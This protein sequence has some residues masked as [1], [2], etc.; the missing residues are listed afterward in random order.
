MEIIEMELEQQMLLHH[1]QDNFEEDEEA[2][3]LDSAREDVQ[4]D[5]R[6]LVK[7]RLNFRFDCKVIL[8]ELS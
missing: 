5:I 7:L 4:E 3:E 2:F 6:E 1:P 8:Q